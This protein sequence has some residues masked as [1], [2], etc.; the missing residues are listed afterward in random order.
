MMS[1]LPGEMFKKVILFFQ[2]IAL[3]HFGHCR[4]VIQICKQIMARSFIWSADTV[5]IVVQLEASNL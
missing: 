1:K 3:S 2:V 4:L 5:W